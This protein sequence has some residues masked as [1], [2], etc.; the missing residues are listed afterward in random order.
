MY[1]LLSFSLSSF[2][3]AMCPSFAAGD[4]TRQVQQEGQASGRRC[5]QAQSTR[6]AKVLGHCSCHG[7][8]RCGGAA[9]CVSK[10]CRRGTLCLCVVCT[11]FYASNQR[12]IDSHCLSSSALHLYLYLC[13]C[14]SRHATSSSGRA[15][16]SV[17]AVRP[18]RREEPTAE[19]KEWPLQ[20]PRNKD[21]ARRMKDVW[22]GASDTL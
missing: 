4:N 9:Y 16:S 19:R 18:S 8:R 21:E 12:S 17:W 7:G 5:R 6:C 2:F 14:R 20:T 11:A 15:K 13:V 3:P 10:G 1:N 22:L